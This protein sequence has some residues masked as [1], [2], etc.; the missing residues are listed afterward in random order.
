M[1]NSASVALTRAVLFVALLA[2]DAAG[3]VGQPANIRVYLPNM[4]EEDWSFLKDPAKKSDF[5]DPVKYVPLGR[6]NWFFTLGG[7]IRYRGEGFR[8]R[9]VGENPSLY[10]TYLLQ[11]YLVGADIHM[12]RRLR[13][14]GEFQSGI[15][16]GKLMTPRPTD[17][18]L[19]D[20][21]Q[22]F[23][24]WKD[25]IGAGH[26]IGLRAGRQ[27]L[28]IGSSRLISASPGLNVKR[29]FDGARFTYR[30]S[31]W[32]IVGSVAKLVS[33]KESWFD[34]RPDHE[35]TFWGGAV[36]RKSPIL[37]RGELG[38]YYLG[39]DRL[40]SVY[41][42][43]EGRERRHTVGINW[44]GA[45]ER[46]DLNYDVIV[47]WGQFLGAPAH[48]WGFSTETG[49]RMPSVRLKPRFS[50]RAD[51]A[52]GDKDPNDPK[53]QS[54]NP[55]FPGSS[56]S[57][58]I[59]LLG[60]TNLTDFTPAVT[61][62]PRSTLVVGFECPNYWRTST[63]DGVYSIDLRVLIRPNVGSGHYVGS[64][65]GFLVV[66]QATRH[67]QIQGAITRFLSGDFL[68]NSFVANGFGFYSATAL[69][70]F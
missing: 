23:V 16:D 43:G 51:F 26:E 27:E 50:A 10:D 67:L 52:S 13:F 40:H 19:G 28:T 29:S 54:F 14:Y 1:K 20:I 21:H 17:Q 22:G 2:L 41:V 24:E 6:E 61:I 31:S 12:G 30:S 62:V 68:K 8:I 3:A 48:G 47:Q 4:S 39:I 60:P 55:L 9:G 33:L 57:G 46:L 25:T 32:R 34:D 59:G 66:W 37:K 18:D 64:N 36:S 56:Y 65:P 38:F 69:Y 15:I 58:A 5:W 11:R 7:E 44:N 35:Q 70:R 63:G 45:G 42:Q 53:L 49:Y